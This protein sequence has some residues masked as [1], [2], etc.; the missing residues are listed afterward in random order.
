MYLLL[1][2]SVWFITGNLT[3]TLRGLDQA[4]R[5]VGEGDYAPIEVKPG[6]FEDEITGL[7]ATLNQMI[8]KVR[9]REERLRKQVES[10]TIQVD[11]AKRQKSVAEVVDSD[12]FRDLKSKAKTMR[13]D[14][15]GDPPAE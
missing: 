4:S 8:E 13:E 6:F 12:F 7:T 14:H 5:R 10:L 1:S 3:R 11:Q 2:G 15:A 9:G